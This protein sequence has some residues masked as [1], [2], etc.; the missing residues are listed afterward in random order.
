M[1]ACL[2]TLWLALCLSCAAA[3]NIGAQTVDL[4]R[5]FDSPAPKAARDLVKR[6][7]DL[8]G[9]DRIDEAVATVKKAIATAP[10]FF[11]AHLEYIRLKADFQGKIDEVKAEYEAL[12]V[13]EPDNPVY[14]MAQ[15]WA[16]G[17]SQMAHYKKVAELA[18]EWSWGHYARSFVIQGRAFYALN[19]KYDGKGEQILAEVIKAIEKDGAA[20]DFYKRR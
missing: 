11:E 13:K 5:R 10:N 19:E 7:I 17:K 14:L 18:P 4:G 1:K 3:L 2:M 16:L 6:G 12:T 9:R 15:A 8:A 20:L